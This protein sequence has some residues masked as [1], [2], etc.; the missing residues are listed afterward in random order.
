MNDDK[1]ILKIMDDFNKDIEK[2]ID[3]IVDSIIEKNEES[4][5]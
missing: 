5:D 3:E 1:E 2:L 4:K